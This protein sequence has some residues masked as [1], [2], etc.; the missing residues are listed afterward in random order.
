VYISRN[1]KRQKPA[2]KTPRNMLFTTPRRKELNMVNFANVPDN[3]F[4]PIPEGDYVCVIDTV[5]D[6]KTKDGKTRMWNT[7]FKILQGSHAGKFLFTNFVHN[8]GGFGNLKKLYSVLGYDVTQNIDME[9]NTED[10]LNRHCVVITELREYNGKMQNSIP[11]AGFE[12]VDA[13]VGA[14]ANDTETVDDD[15]PY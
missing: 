13:S 6:T 10:I 12:A 9:L 3:E 15:L 14:P 5:K 7:K 8:E 4:L 1:R 11:Y 2:Y